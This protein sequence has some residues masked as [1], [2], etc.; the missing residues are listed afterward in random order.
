MRPMREM[1]TMKLSR[2][3][4]LP[5]VLLG[6]LVSMAVSAGPVIEQWQTSK[7]TRVFFVEAPELPM[8]DIKVVFD[9]GSA[10]DGDAFGIAQ[11]TNG[12]LEEGAGD[13]DV[14]QIARGFDD[15]GARFSSGSARDMATLSLRSLTQKGLLEPALELFATVTGQATFPLKAVER[16]RDQMLVSLVNQEQK[17]GTIASKAFA[18]S[19]YGG[20]PYASPDGG[21]KASVKAI[22]R[23]ALIKFYRQYY[24][25]SN[26]MV[27]IVGAVGRQRAELIA[28]EVTRFL[29]KG[30]RVAALPVPEPIAAREQRLEHDSSQT[31]ILLGQL[32]YRRGDDDKFALYLGNYILGG[33]GFVS[34][35]TN[36]V[37]EKRGL[38]YSVYSYFNPLRQTGT[39]VLGLQTQNAKADESL[40]VI[41]ETLALF[42]KEGPSEKELI[43]AKK[44][45][46]G[47]FPLKIDSNSDLMGYLLVIGF[48]GF[49]LDYLETFNDRIN[50][51]SLEQIRETFRRR[52]DPAKMH[53]VMVGGKR[54]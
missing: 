6:S 30:E 42:L 45:I 18:A 53:L 52:V 29:P 12:M 9:A 44:N 3:I 49:P 4:V 33:G 27:V 21:T 36:E 1:I 37:R 7:G 50:A 41:R 17:P 16:V 10:R 47:G 23:E 54:S 28:E 11:F 34:R 51:V 2:L 46:T 14:E 32:G 22:T 15:L 13:L 31:H 48:Y 19:L 39:F 25:S 8:V 20:H 26:A 24:V 5:G 38:S 35:L 43:A 40:R